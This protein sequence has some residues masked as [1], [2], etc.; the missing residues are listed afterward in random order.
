MRA[1]VRKRTQHRWLTCLALW[2]AAI[3]CSLARADDG[4]DG[5]S[6]LMR[7][8]REVNLELK[9]P[10]RVNLS[11]LSATDALLI[12]GPRQS[13][14][15]APITAFLREGGRV[16]LL[17]DVGSGDR[18]L[19]AYQVSRKLPST[20]DVPALRG[21]KHLL[22]A[23]PASEHPLVEG[24]PLLLTN[25]AAELHHPDL[26][27]V[28]TFG[29]AP[30]ALVLA[31]AIGA[32]R[33][34]AVGDATVV[35]N[36]MMAIEAHRRFAKNLLEYLSR[37]GGRIWL[38]GPNTEIQGSYGS[39]R[40]SLSRLDEWLRNA[41]HPDLPGNALIVLGLAALAV[42]CVF[43]VSLLPRRSPYVRPDLFPKSLVFA[44]YSGRVAVAAQAGVNLVWSLLDYRR[45]LEAE[46]SHRLKLEGP[47]DARQA[48]VRARERGLTTAEGGE[49]EGLLASLSTLSQTMDADG[50]P[51]RIGAADLGNVVRKGERLLS[52][53]GN[54]RG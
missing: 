12:V 22:L 44:G 49:L 45:E 26:R 11:K 29:R 51:A 28:L 4:W 41:S 18:L 43:G 53:L 47:F 3:S 30:H 38:I 15:V 9:A 50:T 7:V 46:L 48:V 34:V 2:V 6:E 8:A 37:P 24:V 21:D 14:P 35:I 16:A 25:R 52:R 1:S 13:L 19:A 23:Y 31:G 42:S 5:L 39:G 10:E 54:E 36:Q 32:G 17:D 40:S 33:L 27:P 20:D